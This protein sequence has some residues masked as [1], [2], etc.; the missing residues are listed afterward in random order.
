MKETLKLKK[1]LLINGKEVKEL[2]YDADEITIKEYKDASNRTISHEV[3]IAESDYYLHLHIGFAAI[4]AVN[5]EIDISDLER[6]KGLD[7]YK[8]SIVGRNFI[9]EALVDFAENLSDE[10]LEIAPDASTPRSNTSKDND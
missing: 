7:L 8:V 4:I 10:Q 3:S 1:P 6:M 5:P 2:T 9:T